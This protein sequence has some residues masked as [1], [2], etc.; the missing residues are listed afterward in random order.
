MYIEIVK[1][2]WTH[3]TGT[4][5]AIDR[6]PK[7]LNRDAVIRAAVDVVEANGLDAL[8]IRAV[9]NRL[10]ASPMAVYNHIADRDDLLLGMLEEV[11]GTMPVTTAAGDVRQQLGSLFGAAHDYLAQHRW[12]LLVLTR[13]DLVPVTS[14]AFADASVGTFLRAG[15]TPADAIYAHGV[16]WHLMLGEILDRHPG[17]PPSPT[18]RDRALRA[19]DPERYPNYVHVLSVIEPSDAAPTCQ[20]AR[21]FGVLLDG[22][23]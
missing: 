13:G 15:L 9:T 6:S 23:L 10:G 18:Q 7:G 5:M 14:F 1:E 20:F 16:C 4:G 12:V 3:S 17:A 19:M 2:R 21:S 11:I 8:T 22:L